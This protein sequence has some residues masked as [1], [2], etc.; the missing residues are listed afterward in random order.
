MQYSESQEMYLETILLLENRRG[1]ARRVE[2]A[3]KLGFTKPSVTCAMKLLKDKGYII[4]NERNHI[5]L[6]SKGRSQAALI[7]E[8]HHLITRL[9]IHLGAKPSVAEE[10][11]C[12]I[13]HVISAD[14]TDTIR[15]YMNEA[16]AFG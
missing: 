10:N 7:Y 1:Y 2:I 16:V 15:K 14:L 13:E 11:A 4:E 12:R 8:R 9:L 6:T 5:R 3:E